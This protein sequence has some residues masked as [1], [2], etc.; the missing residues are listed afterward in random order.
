MHMPAHTNI[1]NESD[2]SAEE[3]GSGGVMNI[4]SISDDQ[5]FEVG[6]K[7]DTGTTSF[8]FTLLAL[9]S[10]AGLGRK[11]L[12]ALVDEFK[13][14]LSNVWKAPSPRVHQALIA[15]KTPSADKILTAIQADSEILLEK[16]G[17]QLYEL[18]QKGVTIIPLK[19]LP[20]SLRKIPDYP[21]WLFVEGDPS[22]LYHK[23]VV[24]VVGT[25]NPTE[26]GKTAAIYV[27]RLLSP[28]PITLVSGLAEGIDES[29]HRESLGD[30]VKNVAFL[31]HGIDFTFPMATADL[32]KQIVDKG[33]AVVT[34]Y[35]PTEHYQKA[36]FVERNRLQAALASIVI[37]VEANL[38]GGTAH[39]IRWARKY[40]REVIGINWK[41]ANGILDDLRAGGSTIIDIFSQKGSK[42]LDQIFRKLAR[43]HKLKTYALAALERKVVREISY[44]TASELDIRH[45]VKAIRKAAKSKAA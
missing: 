39:T 18:Q 19:K 6:H 4:D 20:A 7:P 12:I 27:T 1:L 42:Q 41:G 11:G 2:R 17:E 25:R 22:V 26:R 44:R 8:E 16:A 9:S 45:L 24:A 33:G 28:Y 36:F 29:A 34:E 15:A 14:N 31:G 21:R 10:I 35:L 3:T 5:L 32:R 38:Q 23:A 30:G 43:S 37:P 40:K 13:G